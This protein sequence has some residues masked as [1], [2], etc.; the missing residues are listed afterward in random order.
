MFIYL[1]S[2]HPETWDAQVKAG[3][4]R[5]EDGIKFNQNLGL[6]D[7]HKFNNLAAKNGALYN[8]LKERKCAFYIDR[9]QGGCFIEDYPYNQELLNEY[10]KMLGDN[11][12]GFQMHEWMSNFLSDLNKCNGNGIKEWT[13]KDIIETIRRAYPMSH[14]FLESMNAKE[15]AE[16]GCPTN[17]DEFMKDAE[18][19]FKDRQK[20]TGGM[21]I[22][23]DSFFLALNL[24]IKNGAKRF[25]PEVG[26]QTPDTRVQ[27]AHAR[28]MAKAHGLSFGT[29][30]E[31]W[32]GDPCCVCCYQREGKNEWNIRA[33]TNDFPFS[34]LDENGGSSRSL[35]RRIHLYSYFAGAEYMS[36]EW[37]MCNTFYDWKNFELSPY[38]KVKLEFIKFVDKYPNIGKTITPIAVV[39]PEDMPALDSI[40]VRSEKEYLGMPAT[41]EM[42]KKV[43][44]VRCGLQKI[45]ADAYPMIGTDWEIRSMRNCKLPDACDIVNEGSLKAENYEYIVDLT[46]SKEFATKYADKIC[47]VEDVEAILEKTLP[48]KV[49]GNIHTLVNKLED[50]SF[51]LMLLNNSGVDRT[52][53]KGELLLAEADTVVTVNCKGKELIQLEG[54]G[55]IQSYENG[56]YKVFVPAGGWFMAK[57]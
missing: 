48:C 13:E 18:K 7:E 6:I 32:R 45:F 10:K 3:L 44:A 17:V 50:G 40:H 49:T 30:Y 37:G 1:H 25:M 11:F 51:M 5:K 34:Y 56:E 41:P 33:H 28:G 39:I 22:P 21:L 38:G 4:V 26:A 52:I 35:Q 15:L 57:F 53:E 24:E 43:D 19:L 14:L 16:N 42:G 54:D 46:G 47:K 29:Y 9:L 2:Y 20:R 12:W 27:I 55:K 8:I 23:V 36:E 31:P